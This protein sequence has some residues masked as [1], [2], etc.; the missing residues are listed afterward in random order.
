MVAR[1]VV[2]A[3]VAV[4]VSA[5][6][7][8]PVPAAPLVSAGGAAPAGRAADLG[9]TLSAMPR[10]VRG[11]DLLG[12]TMTVWDAGPG[13]GTRAAELRLPD[14]VDVVS[15]RERGCVDSGRTVRCAFSRIAPRHSRAVHILGIVRPDAS[16]TLR[17]TAR[18]VGPSDRA[19]RDDTAEADVPV[20]PGTDIA[21]RL[22]TPRRGRPGTGARRARE[23]REG[24]VVPVRA[25]VANRGPRTARKVTLN[26]GVHDATLVKMTGGKCSDLRKDR[27]GRY[28]R[29]LLGRLRPGRSRTIAAY[30]RKGRGSGTLAASTELDLGD[31]N[32]SNNVAM[33]VIR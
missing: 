8:G 26:L 27:S 18:L 17:A 11:G 10:P 14:A 22:D 21:V 9:V 16:G 12:Y 33:T 6:G 1:A 30:L 7:A 5:A 24:D 28:L 2:G 3:G 13:A 15:V 4:G 32:P 23:A 19:A 31:T 29:C 25:T 20:T